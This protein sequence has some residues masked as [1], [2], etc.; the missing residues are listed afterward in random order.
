MV[1]SSMRLTIIAGMRR[2]S[3][4]ASVLLVGLAFTL[5]SRD[6][7][8]RLKKAGA[9]ER[10]AF[11]RRGSAS[12]EI[13]VNASPTRDVFANKLSATHGRYTHG[14]YE[15]IKKLTAHVKA[16]GLSER[17]ESK[18]VGR[19]PLLPCPAGPMRMCW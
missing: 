5:I 1:V 8:P 12:R 17:T 14:W 3:L 4:F 11:F 18:V 7:D 2:T 10:A 15:P 6:A 16:A 9:G 19:V 13:S